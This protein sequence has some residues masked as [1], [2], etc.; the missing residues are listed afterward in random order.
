MTYIR[1][2]L[3][4]DQ[5]SRISYLLEHTNWENGQVTGGGVRKKNLQAVDSCPAL[6][7]MDDIIYK[8]LDSDGGF[9]NLTMPWKTNKI[10]ISK[11]EVGGFYKPHIDVAIMGHYSTTVFLNDD[12][13][14]G[15]LEL[16]INGKSEKYKLPKGHA[17]T[18][19]SGTP[20]CVHE[21]TSGVRYVGVTWTTSR[22]Q[23]EFIRGIGTEIRRAME[24]CPQDDV[25]TMGD[26]LNSPKE[27][28]SNLIQNIYREYGQYGN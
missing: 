12:Y 7:E 4:D 20:H 3:N 15:E 14:G 1:K 8:A 25:E 22:I 21:I 19:K 27:I 9:F 16:H 23:D 13:E 18:Y 17:I 28:L 5:L 10:L 11:T 2:I 6:T 26:F 24:L